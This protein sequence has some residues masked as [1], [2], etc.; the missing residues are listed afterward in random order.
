VFL[1]TSKEMNMTG[2]NFAS[3]V[4]P[5]TLATMLIAGG[6]ASSL[7]CNSDVKRQ[8]DSNYVLQ[9]EP[10][11]ALDVLAARKDAKNQQEV[12]VVGRIGGRVDPWINELAAFP[13]V[14]RSLTPCNEIEGDT[15]ATPW[16]YCCEPDLADATVLVTFVDE[17][18]QMV[19]T[20]ARDLL[21]IKELDTVIV[22]GKAKRD[23]AGNVTIL[24]SKLYV[25]GETTP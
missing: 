8:I 21:P 19:R 23:D 5:R 3:I 14:D 11:G 10:Q 7:S 15:C 9:E 24:A 22:Q 18:G 25:K 1:E 20:A 13:I 6:L 16:D 2:L 12:V 17:N 4:C